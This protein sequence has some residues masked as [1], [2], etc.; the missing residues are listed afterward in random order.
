MGGGLGLKSDLLIWQ[1]Q[2]SSSRLSSL[3][4]VTNPRDWLGVWRLLKIKDWCSHCLWRNIQCFCCFTVANA[5][6]GTVTAFC[7]RSQSLLLIVE[8]ALLTA[9]AVLFLVQVVQLLYGQCLLTLLHVNPWPG[10][11]DY[12]IYW[13]VMSRVFVM[14]RVDLRL[15]KILSHLHWRAITMN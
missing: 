8:A 2:F 10:F 5:F 11:N 7:F 3:G 9:H 15:L 4:L 6:E 13:F 14:L 1:E 12:G